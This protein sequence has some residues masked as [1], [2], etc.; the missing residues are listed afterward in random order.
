MRIISEWFKIFK[1]Q[2]FKS[3][4]VLY[5]LR[6]INYTADDEIQNICIYLVS[7]TIPK[8]NKKKIYL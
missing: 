7:L 1:I 8:S 2:K 6:C 5:A 4:L 3:K